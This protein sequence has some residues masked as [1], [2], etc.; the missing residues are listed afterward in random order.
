MFRLILIVLAALPALAADDPWDK[1]RKLKSG[2]EIRVVKKGG[3]TPVLGKFDEAR[4][5]VLVLVV[6]NEQTAIQRGEIDRIDAR[7]SS[8]RVKTDSKTTT[9][10]PDASKPPA[11][12]PAA[13]A[14]PSTNTSTG[15]T[16]GSKP[17]FETVYSRLPRPAA[18]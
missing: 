3:K 16:V 12:P 10:D 6:R 7:P 2:T 5:D 15:L 4:E 13:G 9:S 11:G 18:K 14:R 17:D 1:V 8:G